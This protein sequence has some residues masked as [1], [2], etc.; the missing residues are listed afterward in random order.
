MRW[1]PP[2]PTLDLF[3]DASR[4]GWGFHS[5]RGHEGAGSWRHFKNLHINTLELA[6]VYLAL[7]RL[8]IRDTTIRVFSDNT[9]LVAVL[10][11]GGSARSIPLR[12]WMAMIHKLLKARDLHLAPFHL[13]GVLNVKADI[14]SRRTPL[15]TEW[16]L[17]RQAFTWITSTWGEPEV[18]LF[19]TRDNN[20]L[21][22]FVS[23][24][25]DDQAV[26]SN[27][28]SLDWNLWKSIYLFPPVNSLSKVLD[29]LQTFQGQALVV[30]PYWPS[31]PWFPR[32]MSLCHP[33]TSIPNPDLTQTIL[34]ESFPAPQFL[35]QRLH[36]FP[37]CGPA[38]SP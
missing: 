36:V 26:G 19:A 24:F 7:T 20:R 2:P 10:K 30:A 37:F 6:A 8:D 28:L 21:P 1:T 38:V 27:S 31:R 14:L 18:D 29:K 3:T 16:M 22:A 23:P 33:P 11:K 25:P 34:G 13:A 17:S 12:S 32:L 15:P 5:N 4:Q 35:Q 9:A